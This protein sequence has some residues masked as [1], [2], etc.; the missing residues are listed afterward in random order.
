[1]QNVMSVQILPSGR[2]TMCNNNDLSRKKAE[3]LYSGSVLTYDQDG[4]PVFGV[5]VAL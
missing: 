4:R 1:M 2:D 5:T 3:D